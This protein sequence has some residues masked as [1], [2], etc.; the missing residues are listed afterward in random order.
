MDFKGLQATRSWTQTTKPHLLHGLEHLEQEQNS[1]DQNKTECFSFFFFFF[2]EYF[3]HFKKI[4]DRWTDRENTSKL[5]LALIAAFRAEGGLV[6]S[7]KLGFDTI[8][9]Q[10]S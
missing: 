7:K 5:Q 2:W 8:E 9:N 1:T 6:F 4:P 3:W 10:P